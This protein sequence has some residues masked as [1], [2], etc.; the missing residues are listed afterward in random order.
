MVPDN[1]ANPANP[2]NQQFDRVVAALEAGAPA[3]FPT[4]TVYGIGVAVGRA[5]TP[6]ILYDL[7]RR[8]HGK[9]VAWLVATPAALATY[10]TATPAY[11]QLLARTFWPGPLTLIVAAAA[12]VPAAF[13]SR[14]GTIALRMPANDLALA[15][16]ARVGAPLATTSANLSGAPAPRSFDA[17]DATLL[18]QV[19]AV[20]S[21]DTEK[22]GIASTIL[23][24]TQNTPLLVRQGALSFAEIQACLTPDALQP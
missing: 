15:L 2:T 14:A 23:D 5:P 21:D 16:I 13:Q 24:C 19:D 12:T 18:S 20:L 6:E 3:I 9:P 4:E 22:S 10:G 17:L 1:P 7:K 11:A 8:D